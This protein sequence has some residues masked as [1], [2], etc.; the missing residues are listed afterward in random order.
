[1][2]TGG[3]QPAPLLLLLLGVIAVRHEMHPLH[4]LLFHAQCLLLLL[5]PCCHCWVPPVYLYLQYQLIPWQLLAAVAVANLSLSPAAANPSLS[6]AAAGEVVAMVV[7]LVL[8]AAAVCSQVAVDHHRPSLLNLQ[9]LPAAASHEPPIAAA[10]PL[11][12][13]ACAAWMSTPEY[14]MI[15]VTV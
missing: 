10:V 7:Y 9:A 8:A 2:Q 5:P 1:M 13:E 3:H 4:L 11:S 14:N 12:A 6:S 15:R